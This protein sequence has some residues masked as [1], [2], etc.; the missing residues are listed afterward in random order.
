MAFGI[1]ELNGAMTGVH[2]YA[3][4]KHNEEGKAAL[5]QANFQNKVAQNVEVKLTNVHE[6][7]DAN[8][9]QKKFDA[10]DK[11]SN[12]YS[13]DGGKEKDKKKEEA[14]KDGKVTPKYTGFDMKI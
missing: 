7:D 9:R 4:L 13:G 10:R 2:D 8:N 1:V 3:T 11:G 14:K 6:S 5:D 12:E